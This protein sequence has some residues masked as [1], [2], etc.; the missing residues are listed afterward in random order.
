MSKNHRSRPPTFN[1][2]RDIIAFFY[3]HPLPPLNRPRP[4]RIKNNALAK[5]YIPKTHD[6]RFVRSAAFPSNSKR[7]N[8]DKITRVHWHL[9]YFGGAIEIGRYSR[10]DDIDVVSRMPFDEY[11]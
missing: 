10:I 1:Y 6:L 8:Y 11:K 3:D 5:T 7:F 4:G 2:Q 9:H